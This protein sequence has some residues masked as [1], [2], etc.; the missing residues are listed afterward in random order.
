MKKIL[1]SAFATLLIPLFAQADKIPEE[2]ALEIANNFISKDAKA[3]RLRML[4]GNLQ[5]PTLAAQT[6]GHY[7]FNIGRENG[8]VVVAADDKAKDVILGYADNGTF[9]ATN[10]PENMKW[11][12]GEYDRQIEYAVKNNV[13]S[14]S[15]TASSASAETRYKDIEPLLTSEWGQDTPYNM[16]CPV[17]NGKTCPTGCV[18]TALAQIMRHNRWPDKGTGRVGNTDF[19]S[20]TFNWD[21]MTDTYSAASSTESK[22]AVATLMRT[23]GIA[24]NMEYSPDGSG[25]ASD[26]AADAMVDY[27]KYSA[28]TQLYRDYTSGTTWM[29]II[30]DNLSRNHPVYYD[31]VTEAMAGHAFVC[32]GYKDGYLHINWGWDGISNGYFLPDAL[33]P[34]VQGTG[35]SIGAFKYYQTIIIDMLNP[36]GEGERFLRPVLN[37][38]L[39]VNKLNLKRS[40]NLSISGSVYC[41]SNESKFCLGVRVYNVATGEAS[42]IKS[43]DTYA[44]GSE[45]VDADGINIALSNLPDADGTYTLEPMAYDFDS[46]RWYPMLQVYSMPK[47]FTVTVV[48][49]NVKVSTDATASIKVDA[50]TA[51]DK[52]YGGEQNTFS[53]KIVCNDGN[54]YSGKIYL[55]FKKGEELLMRESDSDIEVYGGFPQVVNITVSAPDEVGEYAV[56]VY[57]DAKGKKK[58][59]DDTTVKVILRDATLKVS[60]QLKLDNATSVDPEN[61]YLPAR[62]S[63]QTKDFNGKVAAIVYDF[64]TKQAVDSVFCE[65]SLKKSSTSLVKI[66]GKLERVEPGK[67]Y[68]ARI[69][70]W[71]NNNE[72]KLIDS[73]KSGSSYYNYVV[74]KTA[75]LSGISSAVNAVQ[76][77]AWEIYSIDGQLL[78]KYNGNIDERLQSLP[79]GL[80]I[81]K[82]GST[83]RKVRN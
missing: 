15:A 38:S 31:G 18:A 21:A 82:S 53:T 64:D 1:F 20:V 40:D 48:G 10:I 29:Q 46:D 23:V 52:V 55:G 42:F 30:Y 73:R 26:E 14:V 34:N 2:K 81:V 16:Y 65:A 37:S 79:K 49:D 11:W 43:A 4:P 6:A 50:P 76:T 77:A 80:Y 69:H 45:G 5:K 66:R 78:C 70:F 72:W 32:D 25:A 58:L 36:D 33:E 3:H 83:I 71:S 35:G 44:G 61:F 51:P 57:G 7:V 60:Q 27:M 17:Q 22:E 74:F 68:F 13:E 19:S 47:I 39:N 75:E 62:I 9:D 67:K 28:A 56:A 8:F 63:C 24:C 41:Q 54:T 12:L 59:S